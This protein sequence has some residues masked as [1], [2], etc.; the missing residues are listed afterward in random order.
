MC[1]HSLANPDF[2]AEGTRNDPGICGYGR[3]GVS[4]YDFGWVVARRGWTPGEQPMRL[5]MH[6]T[7][8]DVLEQCLGRRESKGCIR[9]PATLNT[10]IDRYG[11]L[12]AAY[13]EA[14]RDGYRQ[15]LLRPDR[16]P[17]PWSGRWLVIV[18]AQ[19]TAR[20]AWAPAHVA[21]PAVK[22]LAPR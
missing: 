3:K 7:D 2:R 6:A 4:V 11:V 21:T 20:P 22:A 12:D 9:I 10:P 8:A 16:Q 19:R 15:W 13:D 1:E 5:Q 14:T 18:D 17:T